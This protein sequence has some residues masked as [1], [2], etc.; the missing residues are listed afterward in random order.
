MQQNVGQL[1]V[2]PIRNGGIYVIIV[3]ELHNKEDKYVI[4]AVSGTKT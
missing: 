4:S 2:K 1:Y 3:K